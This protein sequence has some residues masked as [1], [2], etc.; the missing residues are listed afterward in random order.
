LKSVKEEFLPSTLKRKVNQWYFFTIIFLL[1][2]GIFL[3]FILISA[4]SEIGFEYGSDDVHLINL[5]DEGNGKSSVLVNTLD[6]VSTNQL[7]ACY[8]SQAQFQLYNKMK[9]GY[10]ND[11]DNSI[12]FLLNPWESNNLIKS[13]VNGKVYIDENILLIISLN[14]TLLIEVEALPFLYIY[15][16]QGIKFT[17][18]SDS[19]QLTIN[20][21]TKDQDGIK[22][23]LN[24]RNLQDKVDFLLSNPKALILLY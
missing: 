6:T 5:G 18:T 16:G 15:E 17:G 12:K 22:I 4:N 2:C 8:C 23:E 24:F 11:K 9:N 13:R 21:I 3:Y 7:V 1:L 14:N 20:K 19:F 10:A